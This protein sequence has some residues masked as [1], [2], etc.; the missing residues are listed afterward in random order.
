MGFNSWNFYH[1][2]ID[3]NIVKAV[4][5]ALIANGMHS[6]G[7]EYVNID[8]CWQV[9]RDA[10]GVIVEDPTRFPSGMKALADYVHSKGLKFGLYTARGSRTCQ[11]RPGSYAHEETDGKTYCGWGLD[12]LKIDN[13]GG[14]NWKDVNTSWIKF[15]KQ[16]DECYNTTGRY[17]WESIEYCS[18]PSD[19]GEWIGETAN[20][21]RTTRDIQATWGSVMSNIHQNDK[22]ASVARP[23][24]FNDPDMLQVGNVGLSYTEQVSHFSLWCVTSAPLLLGTD[25]VH[26]KKETLAILTNRDAV[27]INQDLGV[28]GAVQG[29]LVRT[30]NGTSEVWVKAL[31]GGSAWGV[32]LLNNADDRERA[33]TLQWSDLGVPP[34]TSLT[35]RDIW[36]ASVP[37]ATH[38]ASYTTQ[39]LPPHGVAFLRVSQ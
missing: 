27:A 22:M 32:V 14:T 18:S 34:S 15:R 12:F 4:A 28:D 2:N 21:W 36:N 7:Y 38:T 23:G 13:C 19:C 8:D 29:R 9:A 30:A 5:D 31:S 25:V 16:F 37:T 6:V 39:P 33:V 11:S 20:S 17:V 26:M 3:E 1:C 35:V 10:Q 24:H